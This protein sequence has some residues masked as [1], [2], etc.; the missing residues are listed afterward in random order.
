[1][2]TLLAIGSVVLALASI[3]RSDTLSDSIWGVAA[4]TQYQA[5]CGNVNVLGAKMAADVTAIVGQEKVNDMMYEVME[6]RHKI[7]NAKWCFVI[8]GTMRP[9]VGD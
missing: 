5:N 3:A 6:E 7:G 9:Y 2:K 4:L 8:R 1:M